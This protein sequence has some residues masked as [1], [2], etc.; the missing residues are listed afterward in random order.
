MP[1][2]TR[3]STPSTSPMTISRIPGSI[4]WPVVGAIQL[5]IGAVFAFA[6]VWYVTLF[7]SQ[8]QVP[9]STI[10]LPVLGPLPLPL[11]LLAGS[12]VISAVLGLLLSL[13]AGW[14]GR[15]AGARIAERVRAAVGSSVTE[16]GFGGLDRVENAR[17]RMVGMT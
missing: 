17:R 15:R 13:H 1:R 3:P 6:V 8:G 16:T 7:L 12:I 4:L 2:P 14:I 9:V 5:A 11:I 10:D